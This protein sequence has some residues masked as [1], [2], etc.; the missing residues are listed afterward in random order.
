MRRL[1]EGVVMFEKVVMKKL[2]RRRIALSFGLAALVALAGHRGV[3]AYDVCEDYHGQGTSCA[4]E[5]MF[6]EA[7]RF[8]S[9]LVAP[10]RFSQ[11][12]IDHAAE[13]RDG[14]G[15]PDIADP[16]YDNTG[17]FNALITI[18]HFW[19]PD[20]SIGQP[21]VEVL[22][23]YANAFQAAQALWTRALGEYAAGNTAE[24]YRFLGMI[25]QF[26]GDPTVPAQG[27]GDKHTD[28]FGGG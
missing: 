6:D 11:E 28:D 20:Q 2:L 5:Q 25:V 27:H 9:A 12:I 18:T 16:L 4:H 13:I 8:Y 1:A 15:A 26:L 23:P 21:M 3:K 14:V 7:L 10:N 19:E 24:A 17:A 22:D